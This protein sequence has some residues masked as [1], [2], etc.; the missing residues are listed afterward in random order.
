MTPEHSPTFYHCQ[1]NPI[2][3][4]QDNQRR[5]SLP[6]LS[7]DINGAIMVGSSPVLFDRLT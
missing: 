1:V 6:Q 7:P 5:M 3:L 4:A 2:R